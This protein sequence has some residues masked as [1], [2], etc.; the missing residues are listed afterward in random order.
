MVHQRTA[1]GPSPPCMIIVVWSKCTN[2]SQP[3]WYKR[4]R[5][6]TRLHRPK[7]GIS[8]QSLRCDIHPEQIIIIGLSSASWGFHNLPENRCGTAKYWSYRPFCGGHQSCFDRN[9]GWYEI[10][11]AQNT[12][13]K[14]KWSLGRKSHA[15]G[16]RNGGR[17]LTIY[18]RTSITRIP[19]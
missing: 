11:W 8:K 10:L 3:Q 5:V 7:S 17:M 19:R 9:Q 16:N 4:H 1:Q 12:V 15:T 2:R 18:S 6:I 13:F 14:N